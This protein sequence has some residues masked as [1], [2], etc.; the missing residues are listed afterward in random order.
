MTAETRI[1]YNRFESGDVVQFI[2]ATPESIRSAVES[3]KRMGNYCAGVLF[4]RWPTPNES[5]TMQ[6]DEVMNAAGLAEY[7]REPLAIDVVRG[8][9]VAV[10]CM[11]LYLAN[12]SAF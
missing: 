6:P 8:A 9:C 7:R 10:N 4:F 3:A 1:G 5:L 11:D 2:V 12:A